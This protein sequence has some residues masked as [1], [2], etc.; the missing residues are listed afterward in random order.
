MIGLSAFARWERAT[1]HESFPRKRLRPETV[2]YLRGSPLLLLAFREIEVH[3]GPPR[4]PNRLLEALPADAYERIAPHLE[5]VDLAHGSV[6]HRPGADISEV[7]FPTSCLLSITVTMGGGST[8]EAGAVGRREMVGVN[9]FM[10]GRE[11]TQTE[12]IVQVAGLAMRSS[13]EPLREEFDGYRHTR[14]VFLKYTQAFIAQLS[15]NVACNRLHAIEQRL[16]RWL[17]DVRDRI[18][19]D[20]LKL[21]HEFI[22]QMLGIRRASVTEAANRFEDKGL[23]QQRRGMVRIVDADRLCGLACECHQVLLDEYDRLLGYDQHPGTL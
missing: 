3:E 1:L 18:G 15:Q 10:G 7:Y 21:T 8:A 9:A 4:P 6:L 12:Y 11:T 23:L 22:S 20:D 5:R 16:A 2:R 14:A 19:S 13:A 17:L